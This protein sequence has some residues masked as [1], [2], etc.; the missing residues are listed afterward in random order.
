[1]AKGGLVFSTKGKYDYPFWKALLWH[2]ILWLLCEVAFFLFL[3][4]GMASVLGV[5]WSL[6][7]YEELVISDRMKS[8]YIEIHKEHIRGFSLGRLGKKGV[9]F[10]VKYSQITRVDVMDE[11]LIIRT[12]HGKYKAQAYKCGKQVKEMIIKQMSHRS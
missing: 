12:A 2:L 8:S 1:M 6:F 3:S 10:T 7:I 5:C 4:P 11:S 9:D